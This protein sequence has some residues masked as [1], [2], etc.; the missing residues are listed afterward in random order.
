MGSKDPQNA[1]NAKAGT[2]N[3]PQGDAPSQ[4]QPP[5]KPCQNKHWFGAR[6]EWQDNGKLVET[7]VKMKLKL[8][9]GE[10][11]EVTLSKGAQPGGKYSTGKILDSTA[12]CEVSFPDLYDAECKLK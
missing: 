9:N 4:D 3:Q 7:G 8:N 12:D 1:Q 11:R 10:D 5:V 2:G 6:V